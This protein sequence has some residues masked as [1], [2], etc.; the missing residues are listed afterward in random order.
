MDHDLFPA[1]AISASPYL[2]ALVAHQLPRAALAHR[3]GPGGQGV[4]HHLYGDDVSGDL[5]VA[6]GALWAAHWLRS[7]PCLAA[8]DPHGWPG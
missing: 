7:L 5:A 6:C 2:P 1:L 3:P 8:A 4:A